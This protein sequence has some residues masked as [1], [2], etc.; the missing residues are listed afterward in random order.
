MFATLLRRAAVVCVPVLLALAAPAAADPISYVVT[1]DTSALAGTTGALDV[2]FNPAD[3]LSQPATATVSNFLTD[4][5]LGAVPSLSGGAAGALPSVLSIANSAQAPLT[6]EVQQALTFG[7]TLSFQL[8]LSGPALD[9]LNGLGSTFS[10]FLLDGSGMPT[11]ADPSFSPLGQVLDVNLNADGSVTPIA[12]PTV[13]GP[14][15]VTVSP[16]AP[17]VP[18]PPT[19]ALLGL[20][21]AGVWAGRRWVRRVRPS[22]LDGDG[23]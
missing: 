6:N 17:A 7:K 19:L 15:V 12:Y 10:L 18:E 3:P 9:Q 21:L 8:T 2:Q 1:V 11:L 22:G 5:T 23:A 16:L 20:G 13:G 4:G 14:S